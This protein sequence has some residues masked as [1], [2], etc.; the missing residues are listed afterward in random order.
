MVNNP[1]TVHLGSVPGSG[2]FPGEGHGNPLQDSCQQNP[3]GQRGL[4]VSS[5]Q[6]R[7]EL[8][9]TGIKHKEV[10]REGLLVQ[11]TP[12]KQNKIKAIKL[13]LPLEARGS[14]TAL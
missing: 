7:R 12:T 3:H 10:Q 2:R 13:A 5:S 9:K 8:D 6:G 1:P 14:G 4:V 11:F